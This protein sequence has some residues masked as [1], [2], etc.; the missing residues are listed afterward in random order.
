MKGFYKI[1][2]I[3]GMAC[4]V[5][6][7]NLGCAVTPVSDSSGQPSTAFQK[8]ISS[9]NNTELASLVVNLAL[10]QVGNKQGTGEFA[11]IP[12]VDSKNTYCDKFVS[13][14]LSV[15]LGNTVSSLYYS[16]YADA[17]AD[18]TA[19]QQLSVINQGT[20][21]K[22]A[23]VFYEQDNNANEGDG[24]VG[25]ADGDGKLISVTTINNGVTHDL[26]DSMGASML[27]WSLSQ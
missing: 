7:L 5:I 21:P 22:G 8:S 1:L 26:I 3:C 11:G 15:A 18:Y 10:G 13:A 19:Q 16:G 17:Y 4:A 2:G 23:I 9:V 6:V 27:G 20:P 14:V 25:I 24:H 12:W